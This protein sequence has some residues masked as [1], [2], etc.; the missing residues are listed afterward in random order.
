MAKICSECGQ[1]SPDS[2]QCCEVCGY[3]SANDPGANTPFRSST[4][5][6]L[7]PLL[8]AG[9]I[10]FGGLLFKITSDVENDAKERAAVSQDVAA[11][12]RLA[13]VQPRASS[14]RVTHLSTKQVGSKHRYFFDVRN[15]GAG[16]FFG[17]VRILLEGRSDPLAQDEFRTTSPLEPNLG[18]SVFIDAFTGPASGHREA[19]I[20]KFRYE[21]RIGDG[22]SDSGS[23]LV[24]PDVV[25]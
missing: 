3:Q 5:I 4:K 8:L 2:A 11:T 22:I 1:V 6:P 9:L 7:G 19:A 18:R 25:D 23:G 13:S 24:G 16:P 21:V 14:I 20:T 12:S 10:V 15:T 17:S